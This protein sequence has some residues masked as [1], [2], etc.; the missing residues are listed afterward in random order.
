MVAALLSLPVT[1]VDTGAVII[2]GHSYMQEE[3][4]ER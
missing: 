2:A 4:A 3:R 1:K